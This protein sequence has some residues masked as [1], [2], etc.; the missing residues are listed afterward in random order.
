MHAA[1]RRAVDERP[2]ERF[3]NFN[4]FARA[5]TNGVPHSDRDSAATG[6]EPASDLLSRIFHGIKQ[7]SRSSVLAASAMGIGL[8]FLGF[9]A[10]KLGQQG[11]QQVARLYQLWDNERAGGDRPSA[12]DK[13][14]AAEGGSGRGQAESARIEIQEFEAALSETIQRLTFPREKFA[15]EMDSIAA[16]LYALD[17]GN[18]LPPGTRYKPLSEIKDCFLNA[19]NALPLTLDVS[20]RG[21]VLEELRTMTSRIGTKYGSPVREPLEERVRRLESELNTDAEFRKEQGMKVLKNA[22]AL[23]N[24][25]PESWEI[26]RPAQN[27]TFFGKP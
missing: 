26:I 11:V 3:A 10:A 20:A 8:L 23:V 13:Q 1:I 21:K 6:K 19:L 5:L 4:L 16:D 27:F 25:R 7:R 2:A 12:P 15:A 24:I 17:P 14:A 18:T 22:T 9:Q